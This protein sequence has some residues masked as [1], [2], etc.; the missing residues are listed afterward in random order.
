MGGF[1]HLGA[2]RG[3]FTGAPAPSGFHLNSGFGS[4]SAGGSGGTP[5]GATNPGSPGA[6][7]GMSG[8]GV[9]GMR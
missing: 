7:S 1:A 3:G 8:T 2:L 9:G 5:T 6:I 4:S